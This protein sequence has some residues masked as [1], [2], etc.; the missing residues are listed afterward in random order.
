MFRVQLNE[1]SK[2]AYIEQAKQLQDLKRRLT[3]C[4]TDAMESRGELEAK[5]AFL[6]AKLE[7]TQ[8]DLVMIMT[9]TRRLF[10]FFRPT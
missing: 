8:I 1:A 5:V 10:C 2:Q 4:E 3:A 7:A 6:T 9:N